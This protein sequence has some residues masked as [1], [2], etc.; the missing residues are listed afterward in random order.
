[1]TKTAPASPAPNASRPSPEPDFPDVPTAL[2]E[3]LERAFPDRCPDA[4]LTDA[5]IR[6]RIG[7]CRVVRFLRRRHER[8]HRAKQ[9]R[10]L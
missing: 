2:L 8:Q 5:E 10:I 6:E 3:A 4:D 7:E 9:G 1:M